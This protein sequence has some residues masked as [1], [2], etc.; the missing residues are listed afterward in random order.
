LLRGFHSDASIALDHFVLRCRIERTLQL[1]KD[2][3][4]NDSAD[5]SRFPAPYDRL[6]V[7]YT[8][9]GLKLLRVTSIAAAGSGVI[10]N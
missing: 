1:V 2:S 10:F 3:D 8:T 5:R 6:R 9:I 7:R 4:A